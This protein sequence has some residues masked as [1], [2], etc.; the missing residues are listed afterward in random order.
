MKNPSK[1]STLS[2][3]E[4]SDVIL[5]VEYSDFEFT[6]EEGSGTGYKPVGTTEHLKYL[7]KFRM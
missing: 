2:E 7:E 4:P 3:S 6:N 1:Q 5:C